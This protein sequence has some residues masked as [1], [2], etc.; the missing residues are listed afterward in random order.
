[1]PAPKPVVAVAPKP[2]CLAPATWRV[3]LLWR[4][5]GGKQRAYLL[6]TM[7]VSDLR[8]QTFPPSLAAA[9]DEATAL[10]TE[11]S[12]DPAN[13]SSIAGRVM[14]P[15]EQSLDKLLKPEVVARL[16]AFLSGRGL[17]WPMV[18][19]MKPWVVM[20]MLTD[21][22]AL[23]TKAGATAA[24][25]PPAPMSPPLDLLLSQRAQARKLTVAGLETVAEQVDAI[26]TMSAA[27]QIAMLEAQ[28][29]AAEATTTK[30]SA[31][32]QLKDAFFCGD[33]EPLARLIV[34]ESAGLNAKLFQALFTTRNQRLAERMAQ[35]LASDDHITVYAIGAGHL[36]GTDGVVARLGRAGF[37]LTRQ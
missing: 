25:G 37:H 28:L 10:Y 8:V 32:A 13:L 20:A 7:H 36:T 17:A 27:E 24:S 30:P 18:L 33:L 34:K 4:I 19:R 14:L 3:P 9:F 15:P 21:K 5:D 23:P 26:E 29:T 31:V 2:T 1:M 16:Q 22:S 11:I 12:F 35:H 6:G